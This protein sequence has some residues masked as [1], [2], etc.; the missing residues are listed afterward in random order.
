MLLVEIVLQDIIALPLLL[1][2][3]FALLVSIVK[4]EFLTQLNALVPLSNLTL[5]CVNHLIAHTASEEDI[6]HNLDLKIQKMSVIKVSSVK[7]EL[8]LQV[9]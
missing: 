6:A 2:L 3:F 7:K 8:N 9:P 4:M 5:E 1:F